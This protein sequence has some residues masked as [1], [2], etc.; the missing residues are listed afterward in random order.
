M[1]IQDRIWYDKMG[2]KNLLPIF[3][4]LPFSVIFYIITSLRRNLYRSGFLKSYNPRAVVVVVGGISVGGTG[5]TPLCIALIEHFQKKGYKVGLLSRG[6][7][8]H[9]RTYPYEV[10]VESSY[11]ECGDEPLLIKKQVGDKAFVVVDPIRSR[12]AKYL[13]EKGVN[14]I[15]TDDGLQHYALGRDVEIIVLDGKRLLG[16]GLVLPAGPLRESPLR[17]KSTPFIVMNCTNAKI[18]SSYTPMQ[19]VEKK[20]VSLDGLEFLEKKSKVCALAGIGNPKRFYDT[21]TKCGFIIDKTLSAA[22]HGVIDDETL[23]SVSQSMPVVMTSKDAVKYAHLLHDNLYELQIEA[24][25][26]NDFYISLDEKISAVLKA[27][28]KTYM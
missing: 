18:I 9:A 25:L 3:L 12:G 17:L 2:W 19:F 21:L 14:L 15:F 10:T 6:Y 8:G 22:D 27:K 4:L 5:K 7:H 28:C 20:A 26:P 11:K 1:A 23:L 16:N 13:E 24:L